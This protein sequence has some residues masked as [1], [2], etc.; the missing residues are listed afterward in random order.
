MY[1]WQNIEVMKI[2]LERKELVKVER[3]I[4][5]YNDKLKYNIERYKRSEVIEKYSRE[6]GLKRISP[7]DYEV[8][9]VRD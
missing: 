8:L 6:R 9:L 5:N 3:R 7:G 4:I 1:V 2:K